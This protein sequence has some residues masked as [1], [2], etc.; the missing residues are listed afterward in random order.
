MQKYITR[1]STKISASLRTMRRFFIFVNLE[2]VGN[3]SFG[4]ETNAQH[5]LN[6]KF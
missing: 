3:L 5:A 1:T 4:L 6:F 2:L